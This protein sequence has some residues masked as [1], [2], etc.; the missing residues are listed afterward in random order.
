LSGLLH[1]TANKSE[2]APQRASPQPNDL[3]RGWTIGAAAFV[4]TTKR[5]PPSPKNVQLRHCY[6]R[7]I[8]KIIDPGRTRTCNPR[9]RRPMPYPLGQ[10]AK[11]IFQKRTTG[12]KR[13]VRHELSLNVGLRSTSVRPFLFYESSC[14]LVALTAASRA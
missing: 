8:D 10:G 13:L 7:C 14:G 3:G 6:N 4:A 11:C 9:R 1:I 12:C 2:H 5:P